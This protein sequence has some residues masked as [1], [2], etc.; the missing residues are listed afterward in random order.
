MRLEGYAPEKIP[1]LSSRLH[2]A[3]FRAVRADT[4]ECIM[5]ENNPVHKFR[6]ASID[7]M[8]PDL[9]RAKKKGNLAGKGVK[10]EGQEEL[11]PKT[12]KGEFVGFALDRIE[13]R[14][15]SPILPC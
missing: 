3:G 1:S 9:L 10:I 11:F 8:L 2:K 14:R 15:Q 6:K 4:K 5:G 13:R 7:I 12:E